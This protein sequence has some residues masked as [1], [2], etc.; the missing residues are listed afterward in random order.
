M[1]KSEYLRKFARV[2]VYRCPTCQR[3]IVFLPCPRCLGE[4]ARQVGLLTREEVAT[5]EPALVARI[6]RHYREA[7]RRRA[8]LWARSQAGLRAEFGHGFGKGFGRGKPGGM[9]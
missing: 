2:P 5:Q 7:E 9:Q 6:K 1:A 3:M 8:A 4:R